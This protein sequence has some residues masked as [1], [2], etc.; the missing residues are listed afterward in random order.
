MKSPKTLGELYA[1]RE[2]LREQGKAFYEKADAIDV[3]LV[4]LWKKDRQ[5][6]IDSEHVLEIEDQFRGQVKAFAPAYAH[7]YK[8][9]LR[10][11]SERD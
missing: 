4:R 9:K 11:I 5:A 1:L 8:L 10:A 3:K 6:K 2:S 7:R